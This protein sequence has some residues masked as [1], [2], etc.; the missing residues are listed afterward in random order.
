MFLTTSTHFLSPLFSGA[1]MKSVFTLSLCLAIFVLLFLSTSIPAVAYAGASD[2]TIF[3]RDAE[4]DGVKLHYLM[5]GDGPRVILLH[6]YAED[7]RMW[8]LI[9]TLLAERFTVSAPD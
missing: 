1:F 7:S 6:S 9:L 2:K 8:T 4:I 5:A 3:S